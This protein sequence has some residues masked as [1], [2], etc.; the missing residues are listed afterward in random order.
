MQQIF[1][2]CSFTEKASAGYMWFLTTL[3]TAMQVAWSEQQDSGS[4]S[5]GPGLALSRCLIMILRKDAHSTT[6]SPC[7]CSLSV[8]GDVVLPPSPQ[9]FL[10]VK[11]LPCLSE[12]PLSKQSWS[13]WG[14]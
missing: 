4:W 2:L 1:T 8:G 13:C 6:V 12:Y 5:F 14:C 11:Y 9:S 7:G 3:M 10:A